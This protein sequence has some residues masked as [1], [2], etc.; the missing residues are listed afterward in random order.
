MDYLEGKI[1]GDNNTC[2]DVT[3]LIEGSNEA[4]GLGL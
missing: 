3:D 1:E 4:R 2:K